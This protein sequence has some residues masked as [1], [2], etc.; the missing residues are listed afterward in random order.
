MAE[1][2][3]RRCLAR[4]Q[5]KGAPADV[6]RP[7]HPLLQSY[8]WPGNVRELEN[9]CER[10]AVFMAQFADLADTDWTGLPHECPELFDGAPAAG[11]GTVAPV[12]ASVGRAEEAR[13][14]LDRHFG[15][16]QATAKALGVSRST[17]WRWM[18]E[19]G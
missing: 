4:L 2:R 14:M 1:R 11:P 17:L 10:L 12:P 15:N 7:I 3:V 9:V 16:H 18:K 6:L 5:V 8:A 19:G 13:R